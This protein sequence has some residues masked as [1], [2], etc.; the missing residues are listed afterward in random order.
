[1]P[2]HNSETVERTYVNAE[3]EDCGAVAGGFLAAVFAENAEL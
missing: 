1:L 2:H 3:A